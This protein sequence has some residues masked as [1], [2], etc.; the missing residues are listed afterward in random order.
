MET[1]FNAIYDVCETIYVE[2]HDGFD[3]ETVAEMYHTAV[4]MLAITA[5][6]AVVALLPLVKKSVKWT[7]GVLKVWTSPISFYVF[8]HREY[9]AM[10]RWERIVASAK[11]NG[12]EIIKIN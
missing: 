3:A 4:L 10:R 9:V 5:G 7:W 6:L 2:T 8:H 11:A 1:L 12:G